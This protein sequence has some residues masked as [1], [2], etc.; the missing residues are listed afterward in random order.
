MRDAL[1]EWES[2]SGIARSGVGYLR[3][4][5]LRTEGGLPD[6]AIM[7]SV[8]LMMAMASSPRRSFNDF[9]ASAVMTAVSR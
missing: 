7:T 1:S 8:D 9:T 2:Y 4:R 3:G 6:L 5:R